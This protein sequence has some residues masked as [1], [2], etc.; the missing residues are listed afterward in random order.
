MTTKISLKYFVLAS[1]LVIGIVPLLIAGFLLSERSGKELRAVESR[2]Q[3]QLVQDKARQIEMFGK[4]NADLV[5]SYAK[6]LELNHDESLLSS[7]VTHAQLKKT[8]AEHPSLLS[9]SIRPTTGEP[10]NIFRSDAISAEELE[11]VS[12]EFLG[13][14]TDGKQ[15]LSQPFKLASSGEI[16]FAIISPV[17]EDEQLSA[18]IIGIVSLRE[19][20]QIMSETKSKPLNEQQLWDAGLPIT[21]VV[22][23]NGKAIAHTDP[24]V[25]NNQ[26]FMNDL[27]IVQEWKASRGQIQSALVPFTANQN[28]ESRNMLG[29]YSTAN[30]N[31]QIILGVVAMQ[32]EK[33]ALASVRDMRNQTW[34]ISF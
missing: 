19:I 2:Y 17:L 20:S 26:R 25:V 34:L 5:E 3:T 21:F 4:R 30:I 7:D 16:V 6:A 8:L 22:D 27:H 13:K 31:G 10:L 12:K 23:E 29:A 15:N 1:L 24:E 28:G 14:I 32:D 11:S 9:F 33:K 18:A